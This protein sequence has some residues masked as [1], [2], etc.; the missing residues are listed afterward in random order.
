MSNDNVFLKASI[1]TLKTD[2]IMEN[3]PSSGIYMNGS[4]FGNGKINT[5]SIEPIDN[6]DSLN[7]G[8]IKVKNGFVELKEIQPNKLDF[9]KLCGINLNDTYLNAEKSIFINDSKFDHREI[10]TDKI[11]TIHESILIS[12]VKICNGIIT[13]KNINQTDQITNTEPTNKNT[14]I[15]AQKVIQPEFK[16][17]KCSEN[18]NKVSILNTVFHKNLLQTPKLQVPIFETD[19]IF[20]KQPN[21]GI[22]IDGCWIR[23]GDI[24]SNGRLLFNT[25]KANSITLN[26]LQIGKLQIGNGL[27]SDFYID[28]DIVSLNRSRYII[29][30]IDHSVSISI[31]AVAKKEFSYIDLPDILCMN[32]DNIYHATVFINDRALIATIE[33]NKIILQHKVQK[34]QT[35]KGSLIYEKSKN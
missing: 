31:H 30:S 29:S 11:N 35:I 28:D 26:S 2:R 7:L 19:A 34:N 8:G 5:S 15:A 22:N 13:C 17:I 33:S 18:D 6:S 9:L 12:G 32:N 3:T 1:K 23:K 16:I 25:I 21:R 10:H 20:E 24:H 27:W 14:T 4:L